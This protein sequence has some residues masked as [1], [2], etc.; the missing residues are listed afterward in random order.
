MYMPTLARFTA[1]DPM[2][3][4]GEPVLLYGLPDGLE[5]SAPSN[6]YGYAGNSPA[7][8]VDPSGLKYGSPGGGRKPAPP[9][10]PTCTVLLECVHLGLPFGPRHCGLNITDSKGSTP[11]NVGGGIG[12]GAKCNIVYSQVFFGAGGSYSPQAA[13]T[14]PE[15]VC[16][17]IRDT[18]VQINAQNLPYVPVPGN[19]DCGAEPSCN[20]NYT[21]KCLLSN[22]GL[23]TNQY[24]VGFP[25]GFAPFGWNHRMKKCTSVADYNPRCGGC[26]CRKWES[27]DDA[28]C[29]PPA[30]AAVIPPTKVY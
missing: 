27:V 21:T 17:C 14:V 9:P 7:N 1:L 29:S 23:S 3:P 8:F 15:S 26:F 11:I 20:S 22:C 6:P 28:W 24:S 4:D 13:W 10:G 5:N 16:K 30:G 12:P 2:P 19:S 25:L 18:A